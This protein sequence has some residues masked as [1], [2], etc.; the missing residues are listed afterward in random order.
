DNTGYDNFTMQSSFGT[1]EFIAIGSNQWGVSAMTELWDN[2]ARTKPF[3]ASFM[4]LNNL[5]D[6]II[7]SPVSADILTYNGTNWVNSAAGVD[8]NIYNSDGTLTGNRVVTGAS[9]Q[10]AFSDCDLY[11]TGFNYQTPTTNT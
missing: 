3:V 5:S 8:I 6:T 4:S 10:L 2:T 7:T 1:V 11:V 9:N